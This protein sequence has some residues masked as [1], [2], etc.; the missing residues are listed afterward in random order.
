MRYSP[1]EPGRFDRQGDAVTVADGHGGE[2]EPID[3][4][5]AMGT[6]RAMR[7]LRPDP[8][9]A[10]LTER[11]LWAATRA[12]S[13][14]NTQAW[15][16]VVVQDAGIRAR[17]GQLYLEALPP[18]VLEEARNPKPAGGD[19]TERRTRRGALHLMTSM[20]EV[21]LLILVCGANVYPAAQPE[22][23][24][25]YSAIHAAAQNLI[26]AARALGL[27]ATFTTLHRMIEPGLRELLAV[28]ADR[29]IGVTIPVGWPDRPFG[30]VTRRPLEDV[31]HRDHW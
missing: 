10:E 26:V 17:I 16:F 9:P 13:P 27:G 23:S 25:M 4:F 22:E 15:D 11:L 19:A 28:P 29:T 7:W 18:A 20:G 30:P 3:V 14:N 2:H 1:V 6:A 5:E 12:S 21:P 31:I 24:M 8:V